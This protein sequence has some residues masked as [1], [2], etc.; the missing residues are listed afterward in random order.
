LFE[1]SLRELLISFR[2]LEFSPVS[3]MVNY[4]LSLFLSAIFGL[5][6]LALGQVQPASTF[7]D[8]MVLQRGKPIA[9]W[10]AAAAGEEVAVSLDGETVEAVADENGR[11]LLRLSARPEGGPYELRF[12]ASNLLVLKDVLVGEV[13]ICSGQSNMSW[14]MSQFEETRAVLEHSSDDQLRLLH[15]PRHASQDPQEAQKANWVLANPVSLKNFSVVAYGFGRHLRETLG[16][17]VGLVLSAWG[18]TRAEAWTREEALSQHEILVPILDRWEETY[19]AYPERKRAYD[20]SLSTW[21]ETK[22]VAEEASKKVPRKP[23]PPVGLADRHAPAR[24]FNGMIQPL[25]PMSIRGVIWYQG[26]SNA[27]RAYQYRTLFPVMI[28]D[29]REAFGQGQFPF[30]FVQLAAYEPKGQHPHVWAELRE[31]QAIALNLPQT[32]MACAIDIG[33]QNN[34]HPPHK[35]EVGRRLALLAQKQSYGFDCVAS[36]PIFSHFDVE[37]AKI[38]VHFSS[39][40]EGLRAGSEG[41]AGFE[42]A[43]EGGEFVPAIAAIDGHTVLVEAKGV[44]EPRHVRYGWRHWPQ[45][46]LTNEVLLPAVP[47]R[48]DA[49]KGVTDDAR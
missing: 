25:V 2:L 14:A 16:V 37:G 31:A 8:H 45:C 18:G 39:T 26:E 29:W 35:L 30:L 33:V 19:A 20:A 15:V 23:S 34:I 13:W 5:S 21:R 17:P 43:S 10:G 12:K 42:I 1:E 28:T 9:I 48:T 40:G 46:N 11:W 36:G 41:V 44:L 49:R 4:R 27:T 6:V 38:R 7:S 3:V 47:F 24:L 32:G 22:K